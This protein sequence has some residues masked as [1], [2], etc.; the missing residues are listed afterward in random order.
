MRTKTIIRTGLL[1]SLFQ[2]LFLVILY[3][4]GHSAPIQAGPTQRLVFLGALVFIPSIIWTLFFYLQD[5][6]EPEP[7]PLIIAPFI[8]GMAA[9][10]LGSEPLNHLFFRVQEWIYASLPL[11][12]L[13]SF[14]VK[15]SIT[16]ILFYIVLRYGFLPLKEFD[17]PVDGMVYGAVTGT[18]FAFVYSFNYLASY[19]SFTL[20]V[21]AFTATVN[22]L[23]YSSVGAVMGYVLAQIKFRDKNPP[24]YFILTVFLG[25]L[26]L[27]MLHLIGE[28]FFVAGNQHAFWLCFISVL[29]YSLIILGYCI[30]KMR[31]LCEKCYTG[32]AIP[33]FRFNALTV[34]FTVLLLLLSG[35]LSNRALIGKKYESKEYGISFRYPHSLSTLSLSSNDQPSALLSKSAKILFSGQSSSPLFTLTIKAE[36]REKESRDI[37]PLRYLGAVQTKSF[38]VEP[39]QVKEKKGQR[40][41]YSYL[42][43]NTLPDSLFPEFIKVYTDIFPSGKNFII[44]TYKAASDHFEEGLLLYQRIMDSLKWDE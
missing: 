30:L 42:E 17:E 23:A 9:V 26:F 43:K 34:L 1:N 3:I 5:R 38:L 44:L 4:I 33:R 37:D 13:G 12:V 25:M 28:L 29:V 6:Y 39:I 40:I 20:Y 18:G 2:I 8:A 35:F 24:A 11:F 21:I 16:S 31:R 19:P 7:I 36:K 14:F 22:V 32:G 27:G 41:A 10:A 15:G